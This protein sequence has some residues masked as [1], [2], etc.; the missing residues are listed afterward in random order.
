M[1][2]PWIEN[3]DSCAQCGAQRVMIAD[4]LCSTCWRESNGDSEMERED[5][6]GD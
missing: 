1:T 6:Y 3:K 5:L 4:G 2:G